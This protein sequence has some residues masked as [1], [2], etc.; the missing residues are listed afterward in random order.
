MQGLSEQVIE[1]LAA[2]FPEVI[3]ESLDE[4]G[5]TCRAVDVER[6][7]M[8]L[9]G[10]EPSG[11]EY[12]A[13]TWA[14]KRRAELEAAR[15][16]DKVLRPDVE[17]SVRFGETENLYIEGDN[18]DALKILRKSYLH[19]VK[20]IYI[21]PPY[22]T[23]HD[24]IYR[25]NFR[26][27][28][29]EERQG[30]LFDD[31]GLRNFSAQSYAENKRANPRYHSDWCSMIYPRLKVAK[32]FLTEDGVIFI[33]IDDNEVMNLRKICDE[34]FGESNF[35]AN[36]VW[37]LGTGTTAGHFARA[38]EYILVYARNK[39]SVSNF[40][41]Y[42]E[43][44]TIIHGALK[45]ISHKNPA[46]EITFPAGFE[47]DGEDAVF[48][49]EIGDSEKEYILSDEMRFIDGKLAAPTTLRAGFAMRNQ[50]LDY[51]A[52]RD[53]FDSKGQKV[54]RFFFNSNGVL[55]YEKDKSIINPKTVLSGIANTKNGTNELE[56]LLGGKFFDFP[57]PS[58]LIQYFIQLAT[59]S[60]SIVLDFFAG[61]STTAHAVMLANSQDFGHRK[62]ILVQI[63]DPTPPNSEAA[64]AKLY[65]ISQ[66]GQERIKR[67]ANSINSLNCD[68]G[69]RLLKIASS[70][71]NPDVYTAPDELTPEKL[72]SLV[73]NIKPGRTALDLLFM[74]ITDSGLPLS[75]PYS[76]ET[77]EGFTIHFYG[78]KTL[79]ACFD[80][81]LSESLITHLAELKPDRA[82]FRDSCFTDSAAKINLEQ[83][84]RHYA[85]K[86]KVNIL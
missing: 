18:L 73:H 68:T 54:K 45:K 2:V 52:G 44:Q 82:I 85:P 14:G 79:A 38:H 31:D 53:V 20:M 43:G 25:D 9:T 57:K 29:E 37:D 51:I 16:T 7:K 40:A 56:K 21:D 41:N 11:K 78:G 34:I 12:Y 1:K 84:F 15:P 69:F 30:Y 6:L 71:L 46:S 72:D 64:K 26:G 8:L 36:L 50:V 13:F 60:D 42:E 28:A 63:P 47:F 17:G 24:F 55:F 83:L 32:D 33:S 39:S 59:D 10:E 22:N 70:N 65:T 86:T 49:G 77:F 27:S 76:A 74:C 4:E 19:R 23:G 80:K 58:T 5:N 67:A 62:F 66:I 75:L 61:S 3:T 48:T 35:I 81:N